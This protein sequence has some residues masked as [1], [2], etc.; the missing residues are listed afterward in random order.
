MEIKC[1]D[2]D[3]IG[4]ISPLGRYR[5]IRMPFGLKNALYYF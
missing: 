5:W 2:R 3:K 4:F 1:K